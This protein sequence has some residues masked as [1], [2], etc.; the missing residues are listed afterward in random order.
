[1]RYG[2]VP[3]ARH[4]AGK[5]SSGRYHIGLR[6]AFVGGE[7]WEGIRWDGIHSAVAIGRCTYAVG[8]TA[9]DKRAM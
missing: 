1:M 9:G 6:Y 7:G 3:G 4:F 5:Q 8:R 2:T